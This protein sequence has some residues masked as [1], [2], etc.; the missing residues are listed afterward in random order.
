MWCDAVINDVIIVD[1]C[2]KLA[3]NWLAQM[4][5]MTC[6][7]NNLYCKKGHMIYNKPSHSSQLHCNHQ[8]E[9]S[10]LLNTVMG[11]LKQD[12]F[13]YKRINL[14][15]SL[16]MWLAEKKLLINWQCMEHF[17]L[18]LGWTI[19]GVFISCLYI[20]LNQPAVR[21]YRNKL[22]YLENVQSS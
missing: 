13:F 20:A 17:N 19:I 15:Y 5:H 8:V 12:Y 4:Q 14:F 11:V 6:L 10:F 21:K 16:N 18:R 3:G 1:V 22:N 2:A 7:L 9:Y